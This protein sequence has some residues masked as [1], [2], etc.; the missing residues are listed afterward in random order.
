MHLLRTH[1]QIFTHILVGN[2]KAEIFVDD[3]YYS[4]L[5]TAGIIRFFK[6]DGEYLERDVSK[7]KRF[8]SFEET[9]KDI[10]I[11]NKLYPV[12]ENRKKAEEFFRYNF[13]GEIE[14]DYGVIVAFFD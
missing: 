4:D 10:K 14:E 11:Y 12:I 6:D 2:K 5:D 3:E 13:D 9:I 1:P 8:N 7:V